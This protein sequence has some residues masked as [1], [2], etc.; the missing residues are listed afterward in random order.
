MPAK[1]AK[2]SS[3][4]TSPASPATGT[5][6]ATTASVPTSVAARVGAPGDWLDRWFGDFPRLWPEWRH[7]V[8]D[9]TVA[10]RVEEFTEGET[11]VVRA[12]MPGIDP[13]RDVE[14]QLSD[15]TLHIRAERRTVAAD[16]TAAGYHSEFRYG[17]FVRSVPLPPGVTSDAVRA[18]YADGIL[19]VRVPIDHAVTEARRIP[20]TRG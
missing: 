6:T 10:L 5:S 13:E 4:S 19:E 11:L 2:T 8:G 14:I 9:G 17:R 20:V 1:T 16:S 3:A 15:H 12:E 7:L 18:R